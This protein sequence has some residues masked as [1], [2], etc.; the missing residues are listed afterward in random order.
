MR[1]AAAARVL[2]NREHSAQRWLC[3]NTRHNTWPQLATYPLRT[4]CWKAIQQELSCSQAI[5]K[6]WRPVGHHCSAKMARKCIRSPRLPAWQY[7]VRISS[8][9]EQQQPPQLRSMHI[10]PA[11][12]YKSTHHNP[13]P[14]WHAALFTPRSTAPACSPHDDHQSRVAPTRCTTPHIHASHS[15][16]ST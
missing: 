13:P 5:V 7:R 9:A 3:T 12:G 4:G 15:T 8:T 10:D 6:H 1:R 2:S 11:A 14:S 16:C